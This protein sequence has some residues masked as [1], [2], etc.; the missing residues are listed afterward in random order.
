MSKPDP[1]PAPAGAPAAAV[2]DPVNRRLRKPALTPQAPAPAVPL[3]DNPADRLQAYFTAVWEERMFDLPFVNPKLPVA[4]VGFRKVD[5]DWV[6]AVLTPWFLSIFL[7]PGGGTLW[8]DLPSGERRTVWLPVGTMDFIAENCGEDGAAHGLTA[9]QYCPLMTSVEHLPDAVAALEIAR[10]ALATVMRPVASSAD[11][12]TAPEVSAPSAAPE[13]P[14]APQ[15]AGPVAESPS[16][17]PAPARRAFL[18]RL[19]GKREG[20]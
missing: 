19:V 16:A 15:E 1:D 18:R 3:A 8:Q 7:L 6:G 12:S 20:R 9:W 2:P 11:S 14:A 5:G 17:E 4:A 13:P 10:D